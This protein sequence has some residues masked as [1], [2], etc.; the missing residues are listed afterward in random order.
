MS[1]RGFD[2]RGK[3]AIVTGATR[4]IGKSIAEYFLALGCEVIGT[5][6]QVKKRIQGNFICLPLDLL[7]D[8]NLDS[9]FRG[10]QDFPRIDIL[11]NNAGINRIEPI[12][13][14]QKENWEE[15]IKVNLTGPMRMMREVGALMIEKKIAGKILNIGSI[16]GVVSK[17]KRDSYSASKFGLIGLTEASALDLAPYNILVN[18]LCP[19]FV[20][21]D[22]TKTILSPL[23]RKKISSEIPLGRFANPEEIARMAVFLC[24]DLNTYITGQTIIVDG[25]Y[26]IR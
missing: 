6:T 15:I 14:I 1:N 23:Q 4:G 17:E 18:A 21:T 16:F 24:S 11:V 3:T 26:V 10:I 20:K 19:G 9:F 12:H 22:A 2:F 13:R 8:R 25:G 5:G 7:D